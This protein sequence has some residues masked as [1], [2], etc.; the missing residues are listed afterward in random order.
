[1]VLVAVGDEY[2]SDPVG[3]FHHVRYV[4]DYQ[5]DAQHPLL[6]ELDSAVDYEDIVGVFEGQHVLAD[7]PQ[8]SEGNYPKLF[9][10]LIVHSYNLA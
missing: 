3:P 8:P 5:V 1:M 7:F 4:G 10:I 6:G 2:P 9:R